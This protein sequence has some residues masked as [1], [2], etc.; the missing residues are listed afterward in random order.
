MTALTD[1]QAEVIRLTAEGYTPIRIAGIL[2]IAASTVHGHLR[3]AQQ[4]TTP[5]PPPPP[6]PAPRPVDP[7]LTLAATASQRPLTP[8][9]TRLLTRLIRDYHRLRALT[10]DYEQTITS[11]RTELIHTR[12]SL[13]GTAKALRTVTARATHA[14]P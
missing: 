11:Q 6:P 12:A 8:D 2:G 14:L 3:R 9:E 4:K 10:A 5:P 1:R 13:A 7:L